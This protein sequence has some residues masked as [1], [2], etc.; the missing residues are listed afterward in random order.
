MAKFTLRFVD[1]FRVSSGDPSVRCTVFVKAGQKLLSGKVRTSGINR[2]A[3]G[4]GITCL[5]ELVSSLDSSS[6][7]P[8]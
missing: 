3:K 1:G 4:D 8:L 6:S 2:G 5:D 7:S